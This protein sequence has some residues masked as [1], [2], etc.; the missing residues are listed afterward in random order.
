MA[1]DQQNTLEALK[2]AIQMEI[3]G[4]QYYLKM[5]QT[6]NNELGAKLFKTLAVEEDSHLQKFEEIYRSIEANKGWP[7][8]DFIPHKGKELKTL[9][10]EASETVQPAS[11]EIES[12]KTAMDMENKTRDYYQK[13]AKEASEDT[14]KTYFEILA[15]EERAHHMVLDDYYEYLKN[16][17]GWFTMKERHSLDGG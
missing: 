7:R 13:R 6:S 8:T 16:P 15:G 11:S 4:K 3:D 17:S 10:S 12:V 2:T 9:F 5:G 14:E 1:I